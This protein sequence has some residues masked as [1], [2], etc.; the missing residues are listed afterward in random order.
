[1]EA[2][3]GITKDLDGFFLAVTIQKVLP[4]RNGK[5]YMEVQGGSSVSKIVLIGERM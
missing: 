4:G 1:M 2:G 5:L 3:S